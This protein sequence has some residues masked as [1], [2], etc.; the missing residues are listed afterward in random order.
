MSRVLAV[1]YELVLMNFVM[2]CFM[3]ESVM[4]LRIVFIVRHRC[5]FVVLCL[6]LN[7]VLFFV[8]YCEVTTSYSVCN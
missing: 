6:V 5:V 4:H 3:R 2:I 7:A 8:P 1:D